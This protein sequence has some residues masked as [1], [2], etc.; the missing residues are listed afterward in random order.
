MMR[1]KQTVRVIS[2]I[3]GVVLV[4]G[5]V[6]SAYAADEP[7]A[8]TDIS[9][10]EEKQS[11]APAVIEE[12]YSDQNLG[13]TIE[14][15]I[16]E[17]VVKVTFTSFDGKEKHEAISTGN[18]LILDGELIEQELSKSVGKIDMD[19]D[20]YSVATLQSASVK[21]GKWQYFDERINTGGMATAVVCIVI[22]A[23]AP[24]LA[25]EIGSGIAGLISAKYSYVQLKGKI[26]YGNDGTYIHY[27]R[28][29][30]LYGNGKDALLSKDFYDSGKRPLK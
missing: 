10:L 15:V 16:T 19:A 28:Y 4:F 17:G 12:V 1:T 27:Q 18:D 14:R 24:W 9:Q 5:S 11:D 26:R 6:V 13:G 22:T 25:L 20:Y 2:M 8:K 30:N 21:W 7:F 3:L 29:S 23:K